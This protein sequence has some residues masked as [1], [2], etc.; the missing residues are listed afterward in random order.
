M[1][2]PGTAGTDPAPDPAVAINQE[3]ERVD[4]LTH[5][6][7]SCLGELPLRDHRA[8]AVRWHRTSCAGLETF[9]DRRDRLCRLRH[10]PC[11]NPAMVITPGLSVHCLIDTGFP[12]TVD[13]IFGPV[14]N[15]C[16]LW[17]T[18]GEEGMNAQ[19]DASNSP[20]VPAPDVDCH[21]W[22]SA[23]PR[24][25]GDSGT[26]R[27]RTVPPVFGHQIKGFRGYPHCPHA[28]QLRR[29]VLLFFLH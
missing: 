1:T 24:G 27:P 26:K 17:K 6:L 10:K 9:F 8:T 3:Q 2:I 4:R 23:R 25:Q 29:F 28:L 11:D 19:F 20:G 22:H 16:G 13:N 21:S 14:D 18:A 5:P 7:L 15:S 12:R